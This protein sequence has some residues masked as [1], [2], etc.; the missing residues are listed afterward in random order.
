[1]K[2]CQ[3]PN[4]FDEIRLALLKQLGVD[5][6]VYY[7]MSG[8]PPEME[9]L[10]SAKRTTERMGMSI[11]VVEAGPAIH[12]MVLRKEGHSRQVEDYKRAI[13]R[14]GQLGVQ[15][16]CYN[17]MPQITDDAMVLRTSFE[18]PTRGGALTTSF[19]RAAFDRDPLLAC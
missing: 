1:M 7:D 11:P 8:M 4:P 13:G 6:V 16:L 14:M 18:T 12:E 5:D 15:V 2:I 10:E 17:F 9:A 19:Q 3:V